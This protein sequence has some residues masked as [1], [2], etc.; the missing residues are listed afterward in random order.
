MALT[1][2]PFADSKELDRVREA[3][4]VNV[5]EVE[6]IGSVAAG[7]G[8]VLYGL[9][10]RSIP[11]LLLGLVG[12]ALIHRG[13]TGH[14]SVYIALGVNAR[15]LNTEH[16]VQGNKGI[17]VVRTITVARAPEEV[18][19]YWRNLENLPRFME[20]VE[21]VRELDPKRSA[22]VVRGPL[23]HNVEWTAQIITDR[24]GQM[25]SWESLPGAEVQNA[26]S[27][28]FEPVNGGSSTEVKVSLQYLPPAGVVGAAVAKLLG[29]APEQ[30]LDEDL[31]R[32]KN[33]I[34]TGAT[35]ASVRDH[36]H[37]ATL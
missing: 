7:A 24:E 3:L 16:G 11:G 9:S 12:G 35:G 25:I 28:W 2:Q 14:C 23:G 5:G 4:N 19:R 21:S 10:R 17:N 20:H 27:V 37:Q 30:Q 8:L 6:R 22:W 31:A 18:Y 13:A 32:F 29:E 36:Q 1:V 34:E 26:G 33:L 15:Q